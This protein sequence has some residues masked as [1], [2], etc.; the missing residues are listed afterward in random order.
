[1]S[2]RVGRAFSLLELVVVL[3]LVGLVSAIAVVRVG[4][5]ADERRPAEAVRTVY[6]VL[7]ESRVEAMQQNRPIAVSVEFVDGLVR[8]EGVGDA[9]DAPAPG[10]RGLDEEGRELERLRVAFAPDGRADAL[11]LRLAGAGLNIQRAFDI[12]LLDA[13]ACD[14]GGSDEA[15]RG[16]G[17]KLWLIRFDPVSGAPRVDEVGSRK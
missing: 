13:W 15:V 1:M 14:R 11:V 16:L 7:L 10:L 3:A 9:V 8:V 2:G 17:G 6:R 5:G 12:G 4:A